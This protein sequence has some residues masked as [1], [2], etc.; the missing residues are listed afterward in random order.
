MKVPTP[1]GALAASLISGG[2][3]QV[4]QMAGS[5]TERTVHSKFDSRPGDVM[6][7]VPGS[8]LITEQHGART[9]L[10]RIALSLEGTTGNDLLCCWLST[11]AAAAAS[12][13]V[14][15]DDS[16]LYF[17]SLP[18]ASDLGNIPLLWKCADL[19]LLRGSH[20]RDEVLDRKRVSAK[21]AD[22]L[23]AGGHATTAGGDDESAAAARSLTADTWL[24][25]QA[26]VKSRGFRVQHPN[27]GELITVL[28]PLAD[29]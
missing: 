18:T 24:W 11:A 5:M 17:R 21:Y 6:L 19:Q 10:G 23:K 1:V 14:G 25:A 7:R 20:L 8:R 13:V 2:N 29:M 4:Q 12:G 15:N 27:T 28:C 26:I 22:A 16:Q 3:W 9:P